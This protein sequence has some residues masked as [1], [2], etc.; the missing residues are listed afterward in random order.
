MA[1]TT[2]PHGALQFVPVFGPAT[3]N[4]Y[5]LTNVGTAAK[6][7]F[8]DIDGDGDLDAL[9]GNNAGNTVVQLNTGSSTAPAF[10]GATTNPYGL[11]SVG[12]VASPS[13]V[14]IDGD[15]DLD[16][17]IGNNQGCIVVRLNA[18]SATAPSFAVATT[19]NPYGLLAVSGV[20]SPSLADIDGDGDLDALI[21]NGAGNTAVQLN[22]GSTTAPAFASANVNPYGLGDVGN[23]AAPSLV[24]I[25]GDGDLDAVIGNNVGN[26]VVQL[27]TGSSAVPAFSAATANPYGLLSVGSNASPSLV[28]IDGDGDLDA[29]I[30]N[31][32]GNIVVFINNASP[33]APVTATSANGS[34]GVGS[35]ISLQVAF[36]ENVIVTGNPTLLLETGTVDRNATYASGSGTKVLT[37][38]YIVQAGDTSADLTQQSATA[39]QLNGGSIKDAAGNNAI[40][41]LAAPTAVGSLGVNANIVIDGVAPRGALFT[42]VFGAATTNPY[43]LASVSGFP[44]V[45][46][47]D[48]DGDGDMDAAIGN[49]SGDTVVQL[50]TG[51]ATG[52]AF[53]AT[54]T[55]P[56]GLADVGSVTSPSFVDIDGDGD[57]DAVIGNKVGNTVVQLNTGSA[58]APAFAAAITNP[59][60]LT[61]V[62]GFASPSFVDIDGDGDLDAVI[63]NV[64][65]NTIVQ[66]NT[67][68][69][70]APA[71]GAATPNPYG[72]ADADGSARPS[73]VDIDGDGD[74]D[75][76]I[77]NNRGNT[78]VQLN[79]GSST[80]PA[81]AAA[82]TNPYNLADVGF[83][84]KP[85]F[86]DIDG[87]GDLDALIGSLVS[88]NTLVFI[89]NASPLAPITS[90]TANGTY[91]AGSVI[92]LQVA[93]NENVIVT[94]AP[95]L[96]L[97]TGA[98]DRNAV[99][100]GATGGAG[101]KVLTFTYTVQAGD[102][103]ADLTQQSATALQLNG[104]S[105]KD[106]A[107]NNA[108]LTLAAP[109][110]AGS[111]GVNA[112][113][114][115][116]TTAPRGALFTPV[117][118]TAAANPY[119]LVNVGSL[120]TP[121]LVDID[122]DGDLDAVIGNGNGGILVHLNTGSSTAP[123]F[124]TA[125]LNPYGLNNVGRT[126]SPFLVD[127]DGDGDLDALIGN[128]AGNT[129]VQLN[130]GSSTAPAFATATTGVYGLGDAGDV[131]SLSFV[132]I[133]GDGDL[134]ALIGNRAGNTLVQLNT[135]SKTA[136]A[137][138]TA[139]T[140]PYGLANAGT[141]ASLSLVDIDGDGDLDAF[142]GDKSGNTSVQLNTGTATAPAFAPATANPFGISN[143]VQY[144]H[145]SFADIDGD[146]DLDALIGN[147][148]GNT[149]VFINN[150][151][152]VAPVTTTANGTY[153]VGSSISLQVAFNENVIV[154]TAG[155]SPTLK[156]ETGSVDRNAVYTG[157]VGGAGSKLLT[158]T[159]TIQAGDTSADLTQQSA[160]ALQLNGGSIKDAAGNNAILTLAAPTAAGSLGA[161]AAIV[162]D[163]TAPRGA[164]F[165]PVFGTATTNPY[166]LGI[167]GF[168]SSPSFV[169]I[170]GDGDL[171]ALTGSSAGDTIVQLNTGSSTSPAFASPSANYGLANVDS[172]VSPSLVDIDGDGDLDALIGNEVG[173]TIVQLNTGSSTAPAFAP[174]SANYG[175]VDVGDFASPSLVDID[176]DGDLDALIGNKVGNTIVQL[177]TGSSTAPAF[178]LPSANYGLADVGFSASPSFVDIDGDG[179]L[180]AL[181]GERFGNTI[182][183][184]N[185][186]S[187][188]APAFAS[189]S[190]NYG[191]MDVGT[192]ASPRFVD[193]DGDGDLDALIGN[194]VGNTI[195]R[196]NTGSPVAPVT[197]TTAN[198]TYAVG[199]GISL[200]VAFNE[201]VIVT[202]NPSLL[203]ET[204]S[205][206]RN[207]TY[208][209]GSGG[210]VLTFTYTVQAG[211]TSAD[212]TQQSATALQ[213]N[214]GSIKDAAGNNAILTLAAPTAVGSLA[215]N[216][217]IVIDGTA[218][219]FASAAVAGN[220]LV[221]SYTEANTL[222]ATNVPAASAFAVVTGGSANAVTAVAVNA[223]AKTVTLTLTTA[224]T[225]GQ[226]VTVAYTDPTTANDPNAI[227]DAA[228]NDAVTLAAT[229]VTNN[230]AD[231][232]APTV[233]SVAVPTN[234]TYVAGQNLDF[235]VTMSEA[236]VVNTTIGVPR[237]AV[238]L[239][240]GGTVY[241]NY[242]SGS[243]TAALVFRATVA[244]G[245]LDTNGITLA[246]SIDANGGT[247]RDAASNNAVLTLSSVASTTGVLVDAVAPTLSI[248]SNVAAVKA[249]ESATI[250]FAFSEVP[251][252]F[253]AGDVTTT[254][255]TLTG[256]AVTGDPKVYTATFTPTANLG[257]GNA[258]ITVAANSYTDAAGN[259]GGAGATPT[260]AIDTLAPTLTITS[261]VST[262][263]IG[264]TAIITLTFS[265]VPG[266]F[267]SS[268]I[269]ASNGTVSGLSLTAD[270][271]VFTVVFTPTAN[272]ANSNASVTVAANNFV[273]AAG[274]NGG[275]GL[276]PVISID[277][278]APSA[279]TI[280]LVAGDDTINAAEATAGVTLSGTG[281]AGATVTLVLSSST[282]LSAGNTAVVNGTGNWSKALTAADIT[283]LGQGAETITASQTDV[284]GNRS[285][286]NATRN[287]TVAT[288]AVGA[289]TINLV[290]GDDII[291]AAEVGSV[292]TGTNLAGNTVALSLGG[293]TRAAT[294]TGTS[295]SYTLVAADI[296]AMGQG[297]ETLS[298]TQTDSAANTSA[299]GTRNITVDTVA[300]TLGITS[301]VAAVKIGETA[302]ITFT[303]SEDPGTS[304]VAGDITTTGGTL[305][306]I[307][308]TG[309]TRFATFAPTA[310]L[311][312]ASASITVAASSYT[313]AAGNNGGSGITPTI[314][315]DTVAPTLAITSNVA[316]V[317]AGETA[318]ITFTFSEAPGASFTAADITTTGGAVSALT[319][320][321]DPK[322][323]TATFTPT[324][325]LASGSASIT[326]A[327]ST[328]TDLAG[329]NGGAGTTPT[330]TIDT[331]AP[332][333]AI[334][335]NVS[336]VKIGET[337]TITFTF[338]EAPG[339]SFTA[340][341][342][343][344]T[345]GTLAGLAVT[346]DPKV[347]TATF[348]PTGNL[349]NGSASVTVA[350]SSYTDAAGNNGGA[351]ST[352][353]LAIDTLAPTLVITSNLAAVKIGE[354]A[355]ITFTF[356]EDPGASFTAADIT[357]TGG[358]LSAI[359][360]AGLTRSATFTPTANT[361]ANA[362]ITVAASSYTDAAGNTGGAGTTPTLAIDTQRPVYA[363]ATVNA[364][365][366]VLTYTEASTLDA[367]NQPAPGAFA[368]LTDGTPNAVTAVTVN[369]AAKT[370][371]LTLTNAV[372]F[373]QTTTVA[374][375]DPTAGNDANAI[376]DAAGN[377]AASLVATTATNTV[378]A[379]PPPP[380]PPTTGIPTSNDSDGDGVP[381]DQE[382]LVPVSPP[383]TVR[384]DGNGDG[385]SDGEQSS[386]TSAPLPTTTGALP[387]TTTRYITVVADAS[388]GLIDTANNNTAIISNFKISTPANL[389]GQPSLSSGAISF[390]ADV[391]IRGITETFSIFVDANSNTSPNGYWV[392]D[393]A[394]NWNNIASNIEQVGDKIR[395]DFAITDGGQF[396]ADGSVNG[397]IAVTG[398]AGTMPL[399]LVGQPP[400]LP[401]GGSF[402]F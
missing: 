388:K 24:D 328:Y 167:A 111:L 181:I 10:A 115:I 374:Y 215:A 35:N 110:A 184:L 178:A 300:P 113:I 43:G 177:N 63:G 238:T 135:G 291:N 15:G 209:S 248:T 318:T 383:G 47:V 270:P 351:G 352:P 288:A 345:G 52:P 78:L 162:I 245:Q 319:V 347:Y 384:G 173:N 237:I 247:L 48:I 255:G 385:I 103:S 342:I 260:I 172:Y 99:Y 315:I 121:R 193:I 224:V 199:S 6:L 253:V 188:T 314:A 346:G 396:D 154:D 327:A 61:D 105:I 17:F 106:A 197:T 221:M 102:T 185:T 14:D 19:T 92:S 203:L 393:K 25:D 285:A 212:L 225:F 242:L 141:S 214:S 159:Y 355:T 230:T 362:S 341:D 73:L 90:T 27:N 96:K 269:I 13:F 331:L 344:T 275:A 86:V 46:L 18:G 117:F 308:G 258:S 126:A 256:L 146:G 232:T 249:G 354:T 16:A 263:K 322:V 363:S 122:G 84:A 108:I 326:V 150:A 20:S 376:Q 366:L 95:T 233:S 333:V 9:I 66:L 310:N 97:E 353:T 272:L 277:T 360:G 316:A 124:A 229:T 175:L 234:A 144:A 42:P 361:T 402:W 391:G 166:G 282:T 280:A 148:A 7:T 5:G 26:I 50:N 155:G 368:V 284:A 83:S 273:D 139:T 359:T 190:A 76:L 36:N 49:Y 267:F 85:S 164:L 240:T 364:N 278:L 227:Q 194:G 29:L 213:L 196:I 31:G 204:G 348:T 156:L 163:T 152:A 123:A 136:P 381:N 3:T 8:V 151:S 186:A 394:G 174:P 93:F 74:L 304:F 30:G 287:I 239:D 254:G 274:N 28:D 398:G 198:G 339:A 171:D 222:D 373:G 57:L 125:S 55:N 389:P 34:Y 223:S 312:S 210:K 44:S 142:I 145:P 109:T 12:F 189:P 367:I 165:T 88:T 33:V 290:A 372:S 335:S 306:T 399:T 303:F 56:Y 67:G 257:S 32:A 298:A 69:S 356:S 70:T 147:E 138:G 127:I 161:N 218:P 118:G 130:T 336:A 75:A 387:G 41:T 192:Y 332:T 236:T 208:T 400:D 207:A 128:S 244:S 157:P 379:P 100:S 302:S 58:I 87:D 54:T 71:F 134:D 329:N 307:T 129:V 369:A 365:Q 283:A 202:G 201:N 286:T 114:V 91:G 38:T 271:K 321:G 62:G 395:I 266:N 158:F 323:Y 176:G 228:G 231:T 206:D 98:L 81:F 160:T 72:L 241:A 337:A 180:D 182:V 21:G 140:N 104:G 382:A 143:V 338:S 82:I 23:I 132:D 217:A 153:G 1:D 324:A 243:G 289:P 301:S 195:V 169:D 94:G 293:N 265:E 297:A 279:P 220:Q 371:T 261:N 77:G 358:T 45:S 137:F 183:Q 79:T 340:S 401:P 187:S 133:D 251:T 311:A 22:T 2:R 68:T 246:T 191:L 262:L 320:T 378:A 119:G 392:Q 296:T 65:G 357:T 281:E 292:I 343:T 235:T 264:Q 377:D 349:A 294:V 200:Q 334:T 325:N 268:S 252:G 276:T 89:N 112:N 149:L 120:A 80:A 131:A 205:V 168:S 53:A 309:L 37:F 11:A 101:S 305:G 211:D 219:V 330:I 170:D 370:V 64:D 40:L 51:S 313:D 226:T 107:G 295:W 350:A 60:G 317:K 386:V 397:S 59:Y 116:D 250:T 259:N 4:P 380:A 39:L 375:T 216:A 299:A 179:D 390:N